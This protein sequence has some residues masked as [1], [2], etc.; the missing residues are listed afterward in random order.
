MP[1]NIKNL[2]KRLP[3]A[4]YDSNKLITKK[5]EKLEEKLKEDAEEEGKA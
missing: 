4:N 2:S 3:G 1:K 5:R